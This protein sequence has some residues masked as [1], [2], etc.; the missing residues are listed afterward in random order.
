MTDQPPYPPYPPSDPDLP[1][2]AATPP[3]T[4]PYGG[5]GTPPPPYGGY[6]AQPPPPPPPPPG[7]YGAP[8]YGG[9]G[10]VP[11]GPPIYDVIQAVKYGWGKFAQNLVPFLV[12]GIAGVV[13]SFGGG[14]IDLVFG[15][16]GILDSQGAVN[17]GLAVV[18]TLAVN[19]LSMIASAVIGLAL[20]RGALDVTSGVPVT[21][22]SVFTRWRFWS[23]FLV[24]L[25]TIL[26]TLV[27]L[28]L[29]I[30]P[31]IVVLFLLWFSAYF[32]MDGERPL[33]AM[34][35]SV[36]LVKANL[37][38]CVLL[39][40]LTIAAWIVA[41][42]SCGLGLIVVQPVATIAAAYS[43]RCFKGDPIAA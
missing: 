43:Y 16:D 30:L 13:V 39:A 24:G 27:G 5:Y 33:A 8:P 31:G 15:N 25:L 38:N 23:I 3:P 17:E 14:G 2:S 29:C 42:C 9:Y 11:P 37:G 28:V 7:G 19:L 21:M 36:R 20:L 18:V 34:S 22:G 41:M 4:P 10:A 1:P 6:G 32:V 40:L 26:L 12:L 35:A